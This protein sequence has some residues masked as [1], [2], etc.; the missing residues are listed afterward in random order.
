MTMS[1]RIQC[2]H[3]QAMIRAVAEWHDED[4]T[5]QEALAYRGLGEVFYNAGKGGGAGGGVS[6]FAPSKYP[7]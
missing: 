5:D 4:V 7:S 6:P 3:V 2:N 1:D